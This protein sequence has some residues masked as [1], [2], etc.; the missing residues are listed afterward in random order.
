VLAHVAHFIGLGS[1]IGLPGPPT[2]LLRTSKRDK[3]MEEA[4]RLGSIRGLESRA[5]VRRRHV[6]FGEA[7]AQQA[8]PRWNDPS[9]VGGSQPADVLLVVGDTVHQR[10]GL[11]KILLPHQAALCAFEK[12]AS[13][14]SKRPELRRTVTSQ[15]SAK[16]TEGVWYAL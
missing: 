7:R 1:G 13:H 3:T 11:G 10:F 16:P 6:Q 12:V 14:S 8:V 5:D 9:T 4:R 15:R 2:L